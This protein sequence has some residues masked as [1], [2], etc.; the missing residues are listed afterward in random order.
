MALP[1]RTAATLLNGY[2]GKQGQFR[3]TNHEGL[4][5]YAQF[6]VT[7]NGDVFNIPG[8]DSAKLPPVPEY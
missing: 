7:D 4:S 5:V 2:G 6:D 3:F 1:G 8:D